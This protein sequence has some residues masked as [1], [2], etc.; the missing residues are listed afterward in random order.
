MQHWFSST[1]QGIPF[2]VLNIYWIQGHLYT[3]FKQKVFFANSSHFSCIIYETN[4]SFRRSVNFIDTNVSKALQE[5][6]PSVCSDAVTHRYPDL[7]VPVRGRLGRGWGGRDKGW[8][9]MS[10]VSIICVSLYVSSLLGF[11]LGVLQ[12]YRM[13]S[14]MYCITVTLYFRQSFQNCETENLRFKITVIPGN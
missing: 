6:W 3:Y 8:G 14:P 13:I 5:L 10:S 9:R 4:V 1:L 7:V 2:Q 12:R 11:T